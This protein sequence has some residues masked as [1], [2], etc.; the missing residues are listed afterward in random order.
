MK[1]ITKGDVA[2]VFVGASCLTNEYCYKGL[3][4]ICVNVGSLLYE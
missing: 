4:C 2:S 3:C 1:T